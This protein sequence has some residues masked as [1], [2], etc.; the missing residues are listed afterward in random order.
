[1]IYEEL[2]NTLWNDK[3]DYVEIEGTANLNPNNYNL[4]VLQLNI[5]SLL[6]H[7][8]ELKY[9]LT[10]LLEHNCKIDVVLLCETFLAKNTLNKVNIPGYAHVCKYRSDHKGGR[11]SILLKNGIPYKR[12]EDLDTFI[13][14]KTESVF[15][16]T[17]SKGRKPII[18][19][20]IYRPPNTDL[21]QFSDNLSNIINKARTTKRKI[22][23]EI[24]LG[25]DHNVDL[26]KG[27]QHLPTHNFIENLTSLSLYPTITRLSRITHHSA[28]LI[29][30]IYVSDQLHHSFGSMLLIN[31]IS[32]HLPALALLKQ[33]KL[34]KQEPLIYES[35]CLNDAKLKEAN[36]RL[37]RKD[38]IGL[39]VGNSCDEKFYQFNNTLKEVSDEIAPMKKVRISAKRRYTEPWMTKGLERAGKTKLK[40]YRKCLESTSTNADHNE[41]I[42]YRNIFNN[43]KRNLKVQYY[44]QKCNQ[45]KDNVKKIIGT[46]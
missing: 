1:M 30:N 31:D 36:H 18:I 29:D 19:G 17:I 33:T 32:D 8:Q 12:R 2:D 39:L 9:L 7:Q 22:P 41:Y 15:I 14:G 27:N 38:W 43:L 5:R 4:S 42:E 23:C 13:E 26:L 3:C 28:T 35:R 21:D 46:Y 25:M 45:Y 40:L 34:F 11:V 24:I 44:Q 6:A 37:M 16:E 20:S 10:Q